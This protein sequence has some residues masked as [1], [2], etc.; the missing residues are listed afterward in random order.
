MNVD[1]RHS[2]DLGI[3][4]EEKAF[5]DILEHMCVKYQFTSDQEKMLELT[6]AMKVTV[7]DSTQYPD[8]S[9]RRTSRNT[10]AVKPM[11][12]L[13]GGSNGRDRSLFL[14]YFRQ[15]RRDCVTPYIQS[16]LI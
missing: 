1:S 2:G 8:W 9:R 14:P 15:A 4:M 6:K 13:G 10:K 12:I 7:D 11:T 5:L 16:L 3:D